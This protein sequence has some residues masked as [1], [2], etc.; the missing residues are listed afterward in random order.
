MTPEEFNKALEAATMFINQF[1]GHLGLR[2]HDL[3]RLAICAP[4]PHSD[5][6]PD[7]L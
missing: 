3:W 4:R 1:L 7:V 6:R 2:R 5:A